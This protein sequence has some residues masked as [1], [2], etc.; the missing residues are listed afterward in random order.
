MRAPLA[1]AVAAALLAAGCA[2]DLGAE[3]TQL[4]GDGLVGE[5]PGWVKRL[6]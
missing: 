2:R 4:R 3:R 6:P 1:T 5:M